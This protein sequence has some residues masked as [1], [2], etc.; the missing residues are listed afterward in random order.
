ML[1][2][3]IAART[4]R[5]V[6]Q[7]AFGS[8]Y[9]PYERLLAAMFFT[10]AAAI[11]GQTA[12]L[13]EGSPPLRVLMSMMIFLVALVLQASVLNK[14]PRLKQFQIIFQN[15]PEALAMAEYS[16]TDRDA[17]RKLADELMTRVAEARVNGRV[18]S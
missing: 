10:A 2:L 3:F 7:A 15:L 1:A 4:V 8:V 12:Y 6:I 16:K 11:S 14:M 18:K 13:L 5:T 17:A 9:G